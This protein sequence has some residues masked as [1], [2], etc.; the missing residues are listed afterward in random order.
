MNIV[1]IVNN[2]AVQEVLCSDPGVRVAVIDR[3][4]DGCDDATT[5]EGIDGGAAALDAYRQGRP[6][7][8]PD[9]VEAVFGALDREL[10]RLSVR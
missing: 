5:M 10:A 2:G 8:A 7:T 6:K 4:V 9:R 1:V 3:D